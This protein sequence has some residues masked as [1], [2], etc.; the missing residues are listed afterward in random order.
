MAAA[1]VWFRGNDMLVRLAK[2]RSSTMA[3]G[4]FLT[5]SGGVTAD[6]W[7]SRSTADASAYL[8]SVALTYTG[9]SGRYEAILQTADF[10][11]AT[12]TLGMAV[13]RVAHGALDGEWRPHFRVDERR[14][15]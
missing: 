10:D 7:S 3:S 11:L 2:L 14:F 9:S 12:G 4:T 8:G 15:A 13:V 6:L 5:N 1:S